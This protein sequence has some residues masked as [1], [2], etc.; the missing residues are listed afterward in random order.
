VVAIKKI[1][2]DLDTDITKKLLILAVREVEILYRLSKV[3]NN[4]FTLKLLDA[5][6]SD[7]AEEDPSKLSEVYL[8][9]EYIEH[10]LNK[11]F[12]QKSS[13]L[14]EERAITLVYNILL[15][16]RFIHSAGVV[17][18][19][20]KPANILVHAHRKSTHSLPPHSHASIR[21]PS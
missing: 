20:L 14:G 8:V 19:D 16:L 15:S 2:I 6:I 4:N 1:E 17:H 9:T 13:D 3:K 21:A 18:R 10:D 11:I 7:E 5:F 12:N